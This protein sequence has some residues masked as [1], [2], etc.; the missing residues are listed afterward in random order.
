MLP[1]EDY[2]PAPAAYLGA[3]VQ[4]PRRAALAQRRTGSHWL[5]EETGRWEQR[6]RALRTCPHC[7]QGVEDVP[8]SLSVCPLYGQVRVRFPFLFS[9]PAPSL[10][11]FMQQDLVLLS[12]VAAEC[13]RMH[14]AA[15]SERAAAAGG[16]AA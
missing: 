16:E 5:A 7:Q 11:E 1:A 14:A 4:R 9:T 15:A 3:V 8:H 12:A 10:C 13:Q 6:P 2:S